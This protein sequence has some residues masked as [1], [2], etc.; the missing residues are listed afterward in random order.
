MPK[1]VKKLAIFICLFLSSFCFFNIAFA[2]EGIT[3]T[4]NGNGTLSYDTTGMNSFLSGLGGTVVD[5]GIYIAHANSGF[6][7]TNWPDPAINGF[8][9]HQTGYNCHASYRTTTWPSQL[10]SIPFSSIAGV[11]TSTGTA[12]IFFQ[13]L[14]TDCIWHNFGYIPM[15]ETNGSSTYTVGSLAPVNGLCGSSNH[16]ELSEM[17]T[18]GLCTSGTPHTYPFS[19]LIWSWTCEGIN[20]GT[21]EN[22]F[23]YANG[24]QNVTSTCG[25]NN[26][27]T[28]SSW[29]DV[30]TNL[31][32][33]CSVGLQ[34]NNAYTS[35]G[36]TWSCT[37]LGVAT[38]VDCSFT[39]TPTSYP[40]L[41]TEVDC[42][43]YSIPDK[44]FCGINNTL[45]SFFLPS[46]TKLDEFNSTMNAL[47]NKAP[48]NYMSV[49]GT[50]LST[51]SNNI[52]TS[53]ISVTIL[54]NTGNINLD[55]I[56]SLVTIIKTFSVVMISIAML[57][58]ARV[59]ISHFFK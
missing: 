46:Q 20:G 2:Q 18:T 36:Q 10:T 59:Y 4:M 6:N 39:V 33:Y 48:F 45:K 47:K 53:D 3:A 52:Q 32:S 29:G 12:Y 25:I 56:S 51:L 7:T 50:S 49:A 30:D 14:T 42:S 34:N 22:C 1:T 24:Q 57:L 37:T 26:G 27:Q 16:L 31:S 8:S 11:G 13:Y 17:P 44:W 58:W 38:S 23:A 21:T 28:F 55:D 43:S 41:P 9:F 5:A 35:S 15:N 19:G 54:G 40:T